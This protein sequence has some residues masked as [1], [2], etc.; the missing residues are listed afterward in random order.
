MRP[1]LFLLVLAASLLAQP[2]LIQGDAGG[3]GRPASA[4]KA[5]NSIADWYTEKPSDTGG[6]NVLTRFGST[7]LLKNIRNNSG[8]VAVV[9]ICFINVPTDTVTYKI[10]AYC[11]TGKIAPVK[12]IVS[13]GATDSLIYDFQLNN[14]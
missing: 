11:Q 4:D 9:R 6:F 5:L 7:M 8:H 2:G 1:I 13:I 12:F 3:M 10:Q 14:F